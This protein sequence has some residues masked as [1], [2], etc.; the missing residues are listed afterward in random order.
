MRH[1]VKVLVVAVMQQF[2]YFIITRDLLPS[3]SPTTLV[4]LRSECLCT[5]PRKHPCT[6][7]AGLVRAR[8]RT[9]LTCYLNDFPCFH[10][11]RLPNTR[12]YFQRWHASQCQGTVGSAGFFFRGIQPY[13]F[14]Y[15]C[16]DLGLRN[17]HDTIRHSP[18]AVH[19]IT[20]PIISI[21]AYA[22]A[23]LAATDPL[24]THPS[25]PSFSMTVMKTSIVDFG[26]NSSR[27]ADTNA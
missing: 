19:D 4:Q 27:T 22:R 3:H 20:N 24:A 1:G 25:T 14:P 18:T 5:F 15:H 9:I 17:L 21:P 10:L 13:F 11:T 6:V 7:N 12:Y 8:Y 23:V 26:N 16:R 2:M